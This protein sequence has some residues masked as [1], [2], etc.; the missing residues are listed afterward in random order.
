[1]PPSLFFDYSC[2]WLKYKAVFFN[3]WVGT[4]MGLR[5]HI[6]GIAAT[7]QSLCF[8]SNPIMAP[9]Y[10]NSV[11]YLIGIVSSCCLALHFLRPVLL[12]LLT[13][14]VVV[15]VQVVGEMGQVGGEGSRL[16]FRK[17]EELVVGPKFHISVYLCMYWVATQKRFKTTGTKDTN[18]CLSLKLNG[19]T[20]HERPSF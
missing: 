10:Q 6:L 4:P 18:F 20:W 11:L 12:R 13:C 3:L 15:K 5:S 16:G 8:G 1:M 19:K 14:R 17:R 9:P 7:F 2:R